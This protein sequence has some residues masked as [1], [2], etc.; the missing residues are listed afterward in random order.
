MEISVTEA[1]GLLKALGSKAADTSDVKKIQTKL[2]ELDK[3][4]SKVAPPEDPG[5]RILFERLLQSV[6]QGETVTVVIVNSPEGEANGNGHATPTPKK[7]STKAPAK[8]VGKAPSK[9]GKVTVPESNKGRVY[10]LWIKSKDKSIA[11]AP[12]YEKAVEGRVKLNT[13]KGWISS[14][15][16]GNDLPAVAT[17]KE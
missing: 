4:G 14:W 6:D 2:G 16:K 7:G 11:K 9:P 3:W 12:D 1:R 5:M 8:T 15:S 13:I 17:K 10:K